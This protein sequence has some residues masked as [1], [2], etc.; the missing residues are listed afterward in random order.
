MEPEELF[1]LELRQISDFID[2]KP[3]ETHSLEFKR[4]SV[5][6]EIELN[7]DDRRLMGEALSG[8]SN[9]TGGILVLGVTTERHHNCDRAKEIVPIQD[10]EAV[11]NRMRS[12]ASE[13]V[14]P[15]LVGLRIR[16]VIAENGAG[17]VLVLVPRGQSRPH[18][19]TAPGHHTY[20]RR[21]MDSFV[22]MQSYE[23]EEMMRIKTSPKLEL[24]YKVVGGGSIGNNHNYSIVF[25]LR[26]ISRVS[27]R[28]PY[29]AYVDSP[30]QPS[31]A[32]YGLDGNGNTLWPRLGRGS[33]QDVIFAA[34]ADSVLH[35]GE[36]LYVSKLD[37]ME[38]RDARMRRDWAVDML[39]DEDE[40]LTLKFRFGCEGAPSEETTISLSREALLNAW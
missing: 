2:S 40:S 4:K 22:P 6:Q 34:G 15:P 10:A 32:E 17:L 7:K 16:A 23:V 27:A 3:E 12:Y 9:A 35:P 38:R 5:P 29:I 11:A 13:C 20:Y 37:Y 26:N 33:S 30:N 24:V 31:V 39:P 14:S 21:V 28:F 18:M 25:G 36:E 8:F 19:S 1:T